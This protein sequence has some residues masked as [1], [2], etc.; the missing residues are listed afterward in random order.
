VSRRAEENSVLWPNVYIAGVGVSLAAEVS[1]ESAISAGRYSRAEAERTGYLAVTEATPDQR[2]PDFAVGAARNAIQQAG[3]HR[4]DIGILLHAVVLHSGIDIF[5]AA[6]YIQKRVA[7]S[8]CF[9]SE[10]RA[11]SNGGLTSLVLA[12]S[13]LVAH[14]ECHAGLITASDCWS[15]PG[16]DRWQ[17]AAWLWGDGGS[18]LVLRRDW[19]LARLVST[20]TTTD[21]E[22][23]GWVRGDEEFGPFRHNAL[24]PIDLR[25]RSAE[26]ERRMPRDEVFRRIDAGLLGAVRQATAEAGSTLAEMSSVAIDFCGQRQMEH[27]YLRPL[28]MT[29]DQTTWSFGR[30]IGHMGAGDQFAGLHYLLES[31]RLCAGDRALILGTGVGFVWTAA[32]VEVL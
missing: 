26:F 14:A 32:V 12:S 1:V 23:E 31:G 16:I 20:A 18:A 25:Q 15:G 2:A 3:L 30:R 11:A 17:S 27:E 9:V 28:G 29:I 21:P 8:R 22:M 13:Y 4:D 6:S 10:V 24:H 19:G 7:T 5:N